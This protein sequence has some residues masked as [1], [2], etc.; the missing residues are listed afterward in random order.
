MSH[1]EGHALFFFFVGC[2]GSSP[3]L[4]LPYHTGALKTDRCEYS[5]KWPYRFV[6]KRRNR[7]ALRRCSVTVIEMSADLR[8]LRGLKDQYA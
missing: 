6:R 8:W 2:E 1:R 4:S 5:T 7:F 3:T